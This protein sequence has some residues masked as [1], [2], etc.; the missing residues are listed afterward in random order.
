MEKINLVSE[1]GDIIE[2]SI[3]EETKVGGVNYY[4]V[5][6][7]EDDDDDEEMEAFIV[8]DLSHE[9]DDEAVIE[10]VEDEEEFNSIAKIFDALVDEI[11]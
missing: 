3:L 1:D 9:D 2:M 10:F 6:D 5:T 4:L 11:D 7:A 8:K